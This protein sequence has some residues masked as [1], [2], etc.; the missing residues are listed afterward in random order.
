MKIKTNARRAFY[1][2]AITGIVFASCQK[3]DIINNETSTDSPTIAVAASATMAAGTPANGTDSVYLMQACKRG[4]RRESLTQ[5]SLP[6]A[7]TD[8]VESNYAGA[9]F[10]KAFAIKNKAAVVAGYIVIVYF[11]DKPVGLL[12]D[13]AGAFVK[14]LEQREKRDINGAGH[15]HGGRFEHRDGRQRDTVAISALPSAVTSYFVTNHA[16]DTLVKA[17]R[18]RDNNLVVLSKNNGVFATVFTANNS[19]VK[20]E[21]LPSKPGR[22]ESIDLSQLPSAA[23]GYLSQTYPNYV[24]KKAF[25]FSQN[26][27]VKGYVVLIDANNTKYAV[28]FDAAGKFVKAK[29]I[30]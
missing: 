2:L 8:Y 10:H 14:V 26:G 7:V 12:F 27:A 1:A 24:F 28:E 20:R 9:T 3:S 22:H 13:S 17:F 21:Q 30:R 5:A 16:G 6:G 4:E 15:H 11:N 19:F 25:S 23:A 18:T 29:T